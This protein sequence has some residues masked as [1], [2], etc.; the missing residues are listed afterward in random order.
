MSQQLPNDMKHFRVPDIT[1]RIGFYGIIIIL[2]L[3]ILSWMGN[4]DHAHKVWQ[5]KQAAS[6]HCHQYRPT[7]ITQ[8]AKASH[9]LSQ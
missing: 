9:G 1:R 2:L 7:G 8:M 6:A 5:L 3:A 4:R